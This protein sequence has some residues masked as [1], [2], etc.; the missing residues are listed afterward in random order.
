[1]VRR[2][3]KTLC[4]LCVYYEPKDSTCHFAPP[5]GPFPVVGKDSWCGKYSPNFDIDPGKTAN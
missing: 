4:W 5:Q 2:T 3:P 1:V